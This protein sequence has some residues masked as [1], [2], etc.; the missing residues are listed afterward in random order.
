MTRFGKFSSG[1]GG[2]QCAVALV[3]ILA[4]AVASS[5]AMPAPQ[6]SA[7]G[8][9]SAINNARVIQMTKLGLGDDIII[10][11]IKTGNCTFVLS[12]ADLAQ[13]KRAGVSDRVIAAMLGASVLTSPRVT[14]DGNP[15]ELHTIGQEKVGGRLGHAVSLGI[16]SVKEKAYLPGQHASLFTSPTPA[17]RVELAPN[18]TAP[19][20]S[21]DDYLLVR[22][23]G[24]GD[25]RELEM[26]SAGGAVGQKVGIRSDRVMKTSYEPMGGRVYKLGAEKP[27]KRGEYLLYVIGSADFI[28]G[29]YG[30]GYDFTVQ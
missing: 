6:T 16:K 11:R 7:A 28:K 14:I 26:A 17:I 15:A 8:S 20:S 4:L 23:D 19:G 9:D 13:L 3:G 2:T 10:A 27:L 21:I 22:M 5:R 12:D 1:A 24:K 30:R 18:T 29:I 25:R